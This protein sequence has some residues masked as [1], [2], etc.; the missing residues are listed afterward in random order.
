LRNTCTR[1]PPPPVLFLFLLPSTLTPRPLSSTRERANIIPLPSLLTLT[2][3]QLSRLRAHHLTSTT[4]QHQRTTRPFVEPRRRD[5]SRPINNKPPPLSDT[6]PHTPLADTPTPRPD[7]DITH[8]PDDHDGFPG[9]P[10]HRYHK[11]GR[12]EAK[13]QERDAQRGPN[14]NGSSSI[15][16]NSCASLFALRFVVCLFRV[17][18]RCFLF[19]L[20]PKIMSAPRNCSPCFQ[21]LCLLFVCPQEAPQETHKRGSRSYK[22]PSFLARGR[23]F[24]TNIPTPCVFPLSFLTPIPVPTTPIGVFSISLISSSNFLKA[25]GREF[26][27]LAYHRSAR[28]VS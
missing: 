11:P 9:Y 10:P 2:L 21:C 26:G 20:S 27:F 16:I 13:S 17:R 28:C 6:P 8:R 19:Y 23:W 7:S 24:Y 5:P 22:Y 25:I 3:Q 12:P 4:R 18:C 15:S 1:P 14:T